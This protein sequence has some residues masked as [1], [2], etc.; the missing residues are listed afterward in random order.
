MCMYNLQQHIKNDTD[1]TDVIEND[2]I[3][4]NQVGSSNFPP[5]GHLIFFFVPTYT[6][7]NKTREIQKNG[8]ERVIV[9][10]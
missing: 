2:Y 7:K 4:M 6:M 3:V 10:S 9:L 8:Q 5:S 1:S